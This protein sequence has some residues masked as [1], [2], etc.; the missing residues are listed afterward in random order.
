M[1]AERTAGVPYRLLNGIGGSEKWNWRST[2]VEPGDEKMWGD[3][4][5]PRGVGGDSLPGTKLKRQV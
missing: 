2:M 5:Q 1:R 4:T 3:E